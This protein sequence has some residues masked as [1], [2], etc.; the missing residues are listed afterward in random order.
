MTIR[1]IW[2]LALAGVVGC[3]GVDEPE[4][5]L[6][7]DL[8]AVGVVQA[9]GRSTELLPWPAGT[10]LPVVTEGPGPHWVYGYSEAALSPFGDAW[11]EG[12]LQTPATCVT[13]LPAPTWFGR[14]EAGELVALDP[15]EAPAVTV[16]GLSTVCPPAEVAA[17]VLDVRGTYERCPQTVARVGCGVQV[18]AECG[19]GELT[20][21]IGPDGAACL[22]RSSGD[23]TCPEAPLQSGMVT[24]CDGP[25]REV[26]PVSVPAEIEAPFT[27]ERFR[28]LDRSPY[29]PS[30]LTGT[31][32][33]FGYHLDNGHMY[34][35]TLLTDGR[36]LATVTAG[37]GGDCR[38]M[39][40]AETELLWLDP[41]TFEILNRVPG[42]NCPVD[43]VA[44]PDGSAFVGELTGSWGLAHYDA[45]GNR[46]GAVESGLT[47][48]QYGL[49]ATLGFEAHDL[50][51]SFFRASLDALENPEAVAA[52]YRRS[53]LSF[54][55][56]TTIAGLPT[57]S[58]AIR[59]DD[60]TAVFIEET[61]RIGWLDVVERRVTRVD[62]FPEQ[63][64]LGIRLLMPHVIDGL[65][66]TSISS[67][68]GGTLWSVG[69]PSRE[70]IVRNP[71]DG[72]YNPIVV[73][74]WPDGRWWTAG[75][76][77]TTA[78]RRAE[79]AFYDPAREAFDP[80]LWTIGDGMP[81]R[82]QVDARGRILVLMPWSAEVLRITPR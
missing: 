57:L 36:Y 28:V 72:A 11:Q 19:L 70:P 65:V 50:L 56:T 10:P 45:A 41:E 23:W 13:A 71:L 18:R 29:L 7:A 75:L 12:V 51:V 40:N 14:L 52:F 35:L 34:T 37:L 62:A 30:L 81:A 54:V 9:D 68:A 60:R 27:T 24:T 6:P 82:T 2:L 76:S 31:N 73:M 46:V 61:D 1:P 33:I 15:N 32:Q 69:A 25:R 66:V 44:G 77:L 8:R 67:F 80:G 79:V 38:A 53:D 74:P 42:P 47:S 16:D 63:D 43:V 26:E 22:E 59:V 58:N 49:E 64:A 39:E 3:P 21:W 5:R 78:D 20:G 55:G 17:L 4:A 48:P